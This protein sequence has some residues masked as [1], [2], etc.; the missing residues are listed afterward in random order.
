MKL[1]IS[2]THWIHTGINGK[3]SRKS[4]A[5][6]AAYLGRSKKYTQ[7]NA[8]YMKHKKLENIF[9]Q[10]LLRTHSLYANMNIY[11]MYHNHIFICQPFKW[12]EILSFFLIMSLTVVDFLVRRS[13]LQLQTAKSPQ[14]PR[15]LKAQYWPNLGR[16]RTGTWKIDIKVAFRNNDWLLIKM[17]TK[18]IYKNYNENTK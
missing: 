7:K 6:L 1:H 13:S 11:S 17:K 12:R 8:R 2:T 15:C 16:R 4:N 10:T 14:V 18:L 5:Y 9:T 3:E